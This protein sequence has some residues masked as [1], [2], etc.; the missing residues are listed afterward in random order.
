MRYVQCKV[1][2][3][4][5]CVNNTQGSN[6]VDAQDKESEEYCGTEEGAVNPLQLVGSQSAN[7][8]LSDFVFRGKK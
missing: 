8:S 5:S 6:S 2:G 3:H 7:E 1:F 4:S